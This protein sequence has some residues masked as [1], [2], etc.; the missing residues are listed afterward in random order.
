MTRPVKGQETEVKSKVPFF[1]PVEKAKESIDEAK[2]P[3]SET[4]AKIFEAQGNFPKAIHSYQS[5][6]LLFPEKKI[7]FADRIQQL[8]KKLN[9]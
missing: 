3:A 8:E 5:L 7:F 4:L 9:K 2:L 6:M 1:N